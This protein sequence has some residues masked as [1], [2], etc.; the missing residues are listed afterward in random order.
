MKRMVSTGRLLLVSLALTGSSLVLAGG[1]GAPRS[2]AA[3]PAPTVPA[4]SVSA[5][6]IP[7]GPTLRS[8]ASARG[9]LIGGAVSGALFDPTEPDYART[10]KTEF[11]AVVAE[12]GMKW[13][14]L[15]TGENN[16]VFDMAD[17]IV[18]KAHADGQTVR[19]HTLIWHGSTAPWLLNIK[20]PVTMRAA[21][22]GHIEGVM[23]HFAG[24]V[25][26]WDVVNEAISDEPDHALRVTQFLELGG[27]D[28]IE[29]SF[30][31]A[32]AADPKARLFYNDYGTEGLGGKSDAVYALVKGLLARGVPINGVG[33]QTHIDT[34][35]SV[36]GSRMVENLKRFRDLGLDVQLT[37]VDVQFRN[38]DDKME[39]A[40]QAQI[41]GDLMRACL[42]VKC[43]AFM[44]WGVDDLSSWRAAGRPLVF[45]E[46][47]DKKPAYAALVRALS[48]KSLSG[49]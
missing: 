31:W 22:R 48:D 24:Q 23:K 37:E 4:K 45:D 10:V 17:A 26:I 9:L 46:N 21:M 43:S 44:M 20:D 13:A 12:N 11:N 27:P 42:S 35:F 41:Y 19:G 29:Q 15:H 16:F 8:L 6:P 3:A 40:Q 32:H 25:P 39:L 47:Y 5:N 18:K 14:A 49:E 2:S 33:F 36:E 30:R 1:A 28:Y 38:G 34:G 7:T